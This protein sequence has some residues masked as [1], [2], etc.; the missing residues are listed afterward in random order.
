M[1]AFDLNQCPATDPG[2]YRNGDEWLVVDI[3]QRRVGDC[4]V[5]CPASTPRISFAESTYPKTREILQRSHEGEI[6]AYRQYAAF[7]KQAKADGYPGIT[8]LFTA[9]AT[10][11]LIH[12]QNFEKI[13]AR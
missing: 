1:T 11:E 5:D 9:L 10:A 6:D 2:I 4:G 12:G 8:Y 7:A 13:L 3:Y